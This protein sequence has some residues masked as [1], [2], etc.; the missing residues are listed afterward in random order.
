MEA[1]FSLNFSENSLFFAGDRFES[2]CAHLRLIMAL[3]AGGQR[4][5]TRT[6]LVRH[7]DLSNL[8]C[9]CPRAIAVAIERLLLTACASAN[10]SGFGFST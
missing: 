7:P 5:V 9:D 10:R 6:L 4:S 8:A 1:C 2:D 3:D